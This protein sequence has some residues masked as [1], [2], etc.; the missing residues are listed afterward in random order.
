MVT[1]WDA[2]ALVPL[3]VNETTTALYIGIAEQTEIIT[4]WGSYLECTSAI[5]R[6][7]RR[8]SPPPQVA[9]SYRMLE[10]LSERWREI[11]PSERLRRAAAR[12]LKTHILRTNDALQLAAALVASGFA[13][14]TAR[15]LAEDKRLR[16]AAEREGFV[17]SL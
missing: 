15:F 2:S 9:E 3:V 16:E 17:V 6:L 13:P 5:V 10:H 12:I 4:W 11:A 8:G 7:A 1:Y 14:D